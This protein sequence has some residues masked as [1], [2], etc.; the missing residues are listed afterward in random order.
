MDQYHSPYLDL[1]LEFETALPLSTRTDQTLLDERETWE[2]REEPAK[3]AW[4]NL[5]E[6]N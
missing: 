6:T 3:E 1:V 2:Y 4:D 5:L